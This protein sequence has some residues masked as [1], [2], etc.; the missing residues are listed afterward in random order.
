MFHNFSFLKKFWKF[1]HIHHYPPLSKQFN[2]GE[3]KKSSSKYPPL[4]YIGVVDSG[5]YLDFPKSPPRTR[6]YRKFWKFAH[7]HHYPPLFQNPTTTTTPVE[8]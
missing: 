5:G 3:M 6:R 7:I 1:A 8:V 2:V 4:C